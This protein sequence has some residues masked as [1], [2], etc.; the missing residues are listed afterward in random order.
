[1]IRGL[2]EGIAAVEAW[3]VSEVLRISRE[4][5]ADFCGLEKQVRRAAPLRFDRMRT[6]WKELFPAL[7]VTAEISVKLARTFEGTVEPLWAGESA[8]G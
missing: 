4:L 8:A 2:E 5:G 3:R 1:V 6:P 7:P